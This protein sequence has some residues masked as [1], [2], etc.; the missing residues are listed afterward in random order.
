MAVVVCP[1]A[2]VVAPPA[3][4]VVPCWGQLLSWDDVPPTTEQPGCTTVS[5]DG[6]VQSV[7]VKCL[8]VKTPAKQKYKSLNPVL[9]ND[10]HRFAG[11]PLRTTSVEHDVPLY[12]ESPTTPAGKFVTAPHCDWVLR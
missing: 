3:A 4:V 1:A 2:V 12:V 8:C 11:W 7:V 6:P 5:V 9:E 10:T